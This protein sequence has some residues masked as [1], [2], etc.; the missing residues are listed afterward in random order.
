MRRACQFNAEVLDH[1]AKKPRLT[2]ETSLEDRKSD[3][4]E[5]KAKVLDNSKKLL[6]S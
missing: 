5:S 6:K 3:D 1:V 4:T 2:A